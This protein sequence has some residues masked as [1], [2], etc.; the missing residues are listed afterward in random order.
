[1]AENYL[2]HMLYESDAEP[3]GLP[4][5]V[6]FWD[7]EQSQVLDKKI[8]SIATLYRGYRKVIP[9][10][11][12][13]YETFEKGG[14]AS[15][16]RRAF[17]FKDKDGKLLSLRYD[18]TT[19]IAR[20]IGMQNGRITLPLRF[21]YTGDVFREQPLHKGRLRQLRQVGIE[22]IG[23]NSVNAD[24]EVITLMGESLARLDPEYTL[25]LGDVSLYRTLFSRLNDKSCEEALHAAVNR[26][27]LISLKI[28]L[29]D[30]GPRDVVDMLCG[31][32]SLSGKP[33]MVF[34]QAEDLASHDE[35][36]KSGIKRL[37]DIVSGLPVSVISRVLVDFGLLKDF[38]YY[39]ALT[40]EGYIPGM[41]FPVANG[42]RYDGLFGSF[43][44][45]CPATGFAVDIGYSV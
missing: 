32:T 45:D 6:I 18:M 11:F 35:T 12:E 3:M 4:D 43:G 40:M 7:E 15:I 19:P 30:N 2:R 38:S 5:G 26:K 29:K 28:L 44:R 33:K 9:P 22:L 25:V 23:D 41:G 42:G 21:W 8:E 14:G 39:S 1:M 13:Y 20:R 36:L 10:A 24:A 31:L 17:S 27:D 16:A 37:S 34:Q